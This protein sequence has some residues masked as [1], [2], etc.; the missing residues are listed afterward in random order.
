MFATLSWTIVDTPPPSFPSRWLV[1]SGCDLVA[2]STMLVT[3]GLDFTPSDRFSCGTAAWKWSG[4]MCR[5]PDLDIL[6]CTCLLRTLALL[7]ADRKTMR[8]TAPSRGQTLPKLNGVFFLYLPNSV[9]LVVIVTSY[10]FLLP[11]LS[12]SL[13]VK[14]ATTRVWLRSCTNR[15][16]STS[17]ISGLRACHMNTAGDA[18]DMSGFKNKEQGVGKKPCSTSTSLPPA[19][20]SSVRV[21]FFFFPSFFRSRQQHVRVATKCSE[22][23]RVSVRMQCRQ[24]GSRDVPV[25]RRG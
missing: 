19:E 24:A 9:W 15:Q 23:A 20:L 12:A 10:L 3:P 2:V 7:R 21:F 14:N 11:C 8:Q 1:V 13:S 6:C 25:L 5:K 22:R 16:Q 4:R 18:V 17:L